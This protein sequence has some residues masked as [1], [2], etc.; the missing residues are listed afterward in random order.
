MSLESK[1]SKSPL[2]KAATFV[3][4]F[5]GISGPLCYLAHL[6]ANPYFTEFSNDLSFVE[7]ALIK[8]PFMIYYLSKTKDFT[9]LL[10][11]LPKE[12]VSNYVPI[13]SLIDIVPAYIGRVKAFERK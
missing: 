4:F 7:L 3:D 8:A 12:F 13:G 1:L 9:S 10:Y 6:S 5:D 11:W 2:L